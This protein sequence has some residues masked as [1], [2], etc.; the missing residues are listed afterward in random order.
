MGELQVAG[1]DALR[2]PPM[3]L[4]TR[5]R[6]ATGIALLLICGFFADRAW[7]NPRDFARAQLLGY[8][9]ASA[10][11]VLFIDLTEL[12]SS[13]FLKAL[14]VWAPR[15]QMDADYAQFVRETNFDYERDLHRLAIAVTKPGSD[16]SFF[17]IADG[18]FDQK[19]IAAFAT[20]LG[21]AG[22]RGERE[23]FVLPL[24]G[25]T[26]QLAFTFLRDDRVAL[27]NEP[28]LLKAAEIKSPLADA[29]DW[30]ERFRRLEGS[31][32]FLV[33]RQDAF[34]SGAIANQ[35]PSG[36]RSPQLAALLTQLQWISIAGKP[37]GNDLR[38]V[39]EGECASERTIRQLADLLNGVVILAEG[40]LNDAKTRQQMNPEAR[41]AYLELLRSADIASF[42]R[43]ATNSVRVVL[44][45]TPNLL[46][47]ARSANS[48][49]PAPPQAGTSKPVQSKGTVRQ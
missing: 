29:T 43:G 25:S 3:K 2:A 41:A 22:K 4:G 32:V 24:S 28:G 16:S 37:M 26:R 33:L 49:I 14:Y 34:A 19:K 45:V 11:A 44:E 46:E 12:R 36:M 42:D 13:P 48:A 7:R 38:V 1:G 20:K 6:V 8:L 9:P 27:S 18:R 21:S 17:A 10:D 5:W 40:G 47:I 30:R 15:G 23:I 31:P 39:L 35:T